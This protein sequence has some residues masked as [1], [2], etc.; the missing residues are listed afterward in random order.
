M[1]EYPVQIMCYC[2]ASGCAQQGLSG[3]QSGVAS[4]ATRTLHDKLPRGIVGQYYVPHQAA[5]SELGNKMMAQQD[6]RRVEVLF[7]PF[8]GYRHK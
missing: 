5:I 6:E 8:R 3:I 4:K 7:I 1:K 2:V